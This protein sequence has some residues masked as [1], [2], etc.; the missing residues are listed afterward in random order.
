MDNI[1]GII[2]RE[3]V[4]Q[5]YVKKFPKIIPWILLGLAGST[6]VIYYAAI[7]QLLNI[8]ISVG[9]SILILSVGFLC[10]IASLCTMPARYP[11]EFLIE[12]T[13]RM[14]A[15][16]W[17]V[18]EQDFAIKKEGLLVYRCRRKGWKV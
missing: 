12:V 7:L 13:P 2:I 16:D 18:V 3:H 5:K 17:L 9:A 4:E 11:E 1:S 15:I 14:S 6:I 8:E 10:G